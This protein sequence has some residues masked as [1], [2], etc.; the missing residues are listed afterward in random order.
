MPNQENAIDEGLV[1][2]KGK[3]GFKQ[4][5]PMKP[6]KHGIKV[7]KRADSIT[8]FVSWFQVNT[9]QPLGGQEHGLRE[10]VVTKL[11]LDLEH[12]YYHSNFDNFFTT[13]QLMRTLL[14][15]RI[16]AT[17][18]TQPNRNRFPAPLKTAKLRHGESIVMQ[19]RGI[20]ACSW[21]DKKIVNFFKT[22]C[23]WNGRG[24]VQRRD[25]DGTLTN[26]NAPPYV[27][28]YNKY[29]VGVDWYKIPVKSYRLYHYLAI[30]FTETT[31]VKAFILRQ[32]SPRHAWTTQLKFRFQL[33]NNFLGNYSSRKRSTRVM[34]VVDG[35]IF[36]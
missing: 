33:I 4:Y 11:S 36:P 31:A 14:D 23:Q 35:K 17:A 26:V 16:Y 20:T 22:N 34:E 10:H 8:H 24:T 21:Q 6:I 13:L 9:G 3:L 25:R 5:M 7:W 15:K 19:K 2:F 1:K 32:F 30:L 27:S 18:T 29:M 12:G 28:G